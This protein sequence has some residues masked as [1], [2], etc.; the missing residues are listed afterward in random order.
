VLWLEL[1]EA[2]LPDAGDEVHGDRNPVAA[3]GVL[4]DERRGDVLQPVQEPLLD[5]PHLPAGLTCR[6]GQQVSLTDDAEG[7]S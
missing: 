2:V 7:A 5:G 4:L 1:V 6:P 3:G